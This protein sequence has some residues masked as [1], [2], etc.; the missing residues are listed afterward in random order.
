MGGVLNPKPHHVLAAP[1]VSSA[2]ADLWSFDWESLAP[3]QIRLGN[4]VGFSGGVTRMSLRAFHDGECLYVRADWDDVAAQ[5][6]LYPWRR[7]ADGWERL[8]SRIEDFEDKM[9]L[10]FPIESSVRFGRLGC[11]Y[12]CHLGGGRDYGYKSTD[13]TL[14]VWH[15]KSARTQS[16]GQTDDKYWTTADPGQRG[17][18]GRKGDPKIAGG[19]E[20]NHVKG[21]NHPA[22]LPDPSG[23]ESPPGVILKSLAVP[24]SPERAA[25]LAEGTIVPGLVTGPF[26]GDRGDVLS[27]ARFEDRQWHV[28]MRRRL[29]TGS[30]Y[31]VQF[32]PGGTYAFGIAA[33]DHTR[34]RHAY[35][36]GAYRL[37][38]DP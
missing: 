31:D 5:R 22:F 25:A 9:A 4:G 14:D 8:D 35:H 34:W 2:P 11:T 23:A 6:N 37:V 3:L 20:M 33:F 36:Y 26:E 29:A 12:A 28:I 10:A 19:Y 38:L 30:P 1:R 32:E 21:E 18:V 24:Y 16:V 15:W 17:P 7:T 27:V 13:V